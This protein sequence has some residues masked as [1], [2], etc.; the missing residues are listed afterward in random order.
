MIFIYVLVCE[1]YIREC[2]TGNCAGTE[3]IRCRWLNLTD[4]S[5]TVYVVCF[6]VAYVHYFFLF[7][8]LLQFSF[9][10]MLCPGLRD[11]PLGYSALTQNQSPNPL[12]F[13]FNPA[14]LPIFPHHS[15][16]Q[17]S[18]FQKW[19]L[20]SLP[21][22]LGMLDLIALTCEWSRHQLLVRKLT[23]EP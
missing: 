19:S 15:A 3:L 23:N 21:K 2:C 20:F 7:S 14:A 11:R 13:A 12:H 9:S 22:C 6:T 5:H 10:S 18:Q 1:Q 16:C 17:Q 8:L 4:L